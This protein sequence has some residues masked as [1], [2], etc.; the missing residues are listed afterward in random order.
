MARNLERHGA[1]G[2][3]REAMTKADRIVAALERY[4]DAR[5]HR[6][7]VAVADLSATSFDEWKAMALDALAAEGKARETFGIVLN[8]ELYSP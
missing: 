7:K 5:D 2:E 1:A 3:E 8:E 4:L 6:V